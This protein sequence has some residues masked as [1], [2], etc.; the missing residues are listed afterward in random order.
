MDHNSNIKS[1]KLYNNVDRIY[2]ELK[3]LGKTDSD[4]LHVDE[5]SNI[6][7]LRIQKTNFQFSIIKLY[8]KLRSRVGALYFIINLC[9]LPSFLLKLYYFLLN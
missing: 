7:T 9:L 6:V 4:P 3:E 2:N 5:F 1:M 8:L